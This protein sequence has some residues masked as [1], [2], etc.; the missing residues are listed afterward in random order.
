MAQIKPYDE[1]KISTMTAMV[2]TNLS[3]NQ[4]NVFNNIKIFVIEPVFTKKKGSINKK[5]LLA[6]YGSII[7]LQLGLYVRGLRLSRS[8]TYWCPSCQIIKKT[9]DDVSVHVNTVEEILGNISKKEI[10]EGWA[11]DTKKIYFRCNVCESFFDISKLKKIA[12]FQNQTTI[13]LSMGDYLVNIML[14][15]DN[16]KISGNK[17]YDKTVELVM[18]LFED[19]IFKISNSYSFR[20]KKSI[21][22]NAKLQPDHMSK[23]LNKSYKED[24]P[25]EIH[26]L[27]DV[28]MKNVGF[29]VDFPIDKKKLNNE[30]NKKEHNEIIH[31]A[32]CESTAATQ[33]NIKFYTEKP[34]NF[35]YNVLTYKL[36]NMKKGFFR[37][38]TEKIYA[39]KKK[40]KKPYIT[41]ISFASG[42]HILTG[43]YDL[44]MEKIYKFFIDILMKN[45]NSIEEKIIKPNISLRDFLAK[46]KILNA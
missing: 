27:F 43:R 19:Y 18:I 12:P 26:F 1:L 9:Q 22:S 34:E 20:T 39:K 25:T 35:V 6:P 32:Q 28:V 45:K 41:M 8:K 11:K 21:L 17:S 23:I 29:K 16:L 13:V 37:S 7:S 42:E 38:T 30:M 31:L 4:K 36:S 15:V 40:D 44:D 14:F 24:E 3:I 2:Y 46:K 5:I 10:K 33:V